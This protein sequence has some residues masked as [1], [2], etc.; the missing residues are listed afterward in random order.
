M[1]VKSLAALTEEE[2]IILQWLNPD[3]YKESYHYNVTWVSSHW[4][5][6]RGTQTTRERSLQIKQLVPGSPYD[7]NVTTETSDATLS[8]PKQ[9]SSCTSMFIT[10]TF[11]P[12][13]FYAVRLLFFF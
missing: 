3:E 11:I 1:S 5:H 2:N 7:F 8:A 12:R 6:I 9:I 13:K 10:V 4:T